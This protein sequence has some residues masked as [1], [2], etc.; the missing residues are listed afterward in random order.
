MLLCVGSFFAA[1]N[2]GNDDWQ[3]YVNGQ[4]EGTVIVL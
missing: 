4:L 3:K 1:E 2:G